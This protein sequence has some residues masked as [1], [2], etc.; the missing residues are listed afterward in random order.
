MVRNLKD[1]SEKEVVFVDANIFLCHAFDTSDDAI[2]FLGK[3][4]TASLR[5]ATSS[6]VLEEVFFKLLMQSSSNYLEKVSVERVK[7]LLRDDT[8]RAMVLQP[9][10][11]YGEYIGILRDAGMKVLELT[12]ADMLAAVEVSRTHPLMVADAAHLAVMQRKKIRH[13]ASGDWD[14]AGVAEITVWS[15]LP[16]SKPTP[17]T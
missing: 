10:A 16:A 5:A 6:L 15:P 7:S 17:K 14:F 3:V 12:G 4:E 9:L 13:L 8:K 11:E 2:G 1:F